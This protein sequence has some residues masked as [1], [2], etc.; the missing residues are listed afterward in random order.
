MS[1]TAAPAHRVHTSQAINPRDEALQGTLERHPYLRN[2]NLRFESRDGRVI[3]RGKVNSYYQ[4][5]MAQEI[6]RRLEGV[7]EIENQLEVTWS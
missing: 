2:R 7:D 6:V 3:L 4:K 1:M 5:V